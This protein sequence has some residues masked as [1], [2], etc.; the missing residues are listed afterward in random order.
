MVHDILPAGAIIQRIMAQ[1][2]QASAGL[3]NVF[4]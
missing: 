3:T 4:D 2:R 1:A